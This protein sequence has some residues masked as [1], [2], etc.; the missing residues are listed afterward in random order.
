M[1]WLI[2][3]FGLLAYPIISLNLLRLTKNK[4]TVRKRLFYASFILTGLSLFGLFTDISTT[5]S[6]INWILVSSIYFSV[7]LVLWWTQFQTN[8]PLKIIGFILMIFIF[9]LGY[10]SGT[11]GALGVGFIVAEYE[12]DTEKRLSDNLIYKEFNLGNVFSDYEYRGRR[13][14]IYKTISWMPIVEWQIQKKEYMNFAAPPNKL[15]VDYKSTENKIYLSASQLSSK[16]STENW[17][18]T[19]MLGQ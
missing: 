15:T 6:A 5:F 14:E 2:I 7:S 12:T 3:L 11:V 9:G 1:N 13:V 10:T 8:K 18:D 16:D 17:A 4:P 19:L